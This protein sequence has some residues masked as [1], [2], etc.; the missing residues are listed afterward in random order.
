M[1]QVKLHAENSQKSNDSIYLFITVH[2]KIFIDYEVASRLNHYYLSHITHHTI[3]YLV[4]ILFLELLY[5]ILLLAF[6]Y[7]TTYVSNLIRS[8]SDMHVIGVVSRNQ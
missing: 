1:F 5:H 7:F 8:I 4:N 2:S 6:D 3:M